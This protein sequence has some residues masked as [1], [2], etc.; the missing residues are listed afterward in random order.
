[1]GYRRHYVSYFRLA[2]RQPGY[3]HGTYNSCVP[4]RAAGSAYP[5][6]RVPLPQNGPA[7][8]LSSAPFLRLISLIKGFQTS[9]HPMWD[10]VGTGWGSYRDTSVV[11]T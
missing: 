10:D 2:A 5:P 11:A 4:V 8:D 3:P 9:P 1:M 7:R 6:H